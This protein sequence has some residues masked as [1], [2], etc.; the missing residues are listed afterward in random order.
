MTEQPT[1]TT[2]RA[3]LYLRVSTPRQMHT[4]V[5]VDPG[6]NSIAT[7]RETCLAKAQNLNAVVAAEFVEPGNSAQSIEKRPVFKQLLSYLEAHRGEVDYVIVYMRSRAFRNSIDAAITKG[8]LGLI[9]VRIISCKEDFGTGPVADAMETVSDAFNELMVRQ[10]GEDIRQKLRH[11][12]LNGGTVSRAK[13]GYL[14]IRASHEGRL[15]NTIGL[16]PERAPLVAK[17]FELYASGEYSVDALEAT[18]ADLGLTT[19]PSGRNPQAMPVSSNK[20]HRMLADPYYAGWVTVD[21]KLI[22]GRHDPIITQQLFDR[23]QDVRRQRSAQGNRDRILEHYLKG[24]IF[25]GRCEANHRRSR[26]IYTEVTK[27]PGR[28]YGYFLCRG[29]QEG[30]CDLPHL[31]SWQVEEQIERHYR[32]LGL[33]DDFVETMTDL[34]SETLSSRQELTQQLHDQVT[35]QL[36][37]LEAREQRLIDLAADG[38]LTR[39]KILERSNG[40]QM[41]RVRLH[42]QLADTS[43]ELAAGAA[44]LGEAIELLRNPLPLYEQ[45]SDELRAQLNATF[46]KRFFVNDDPLIVTHDEAQAPFDEIREASVVYH[47]YKSLTLGQ[48]QSHRTKK[49]PTANGK[50]SSFSRIL[51][52]SDV[53][54]VQSSSKHHLVELR[55]LEP[56]TPTLPVWCATSCATAPCEPRAGGAEPEQ[57]TTRPLHAGVTRAPA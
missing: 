53:V 54:P 25:C 38:L 27:G 8:A 48:R 41:E 35:K 12:M 9:G 29:R 37:K 2:P 34:I 19:R 16:D 46:F 43:A 33:N 6:G 50:A 15:F 45:G 49:R 39:S 26:L 40:I 23:V 44:R 7:Q 20:L 30:F 22:E 42:A 10:N 36:H 52:L 3:V 5:D 21:D 47:R 31:P 17:A 57:N 18:M 14:N 1:R 4:G 13:L 11:K 56:L 24:M 55:G 28:V 32:D 51:V